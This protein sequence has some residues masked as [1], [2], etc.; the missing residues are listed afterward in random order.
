MR[1]A[2]GCSRKGGMS[3]GDQHRKLSL[4]SLCE[5]DAA[6]ERIERA[7]REGNLEATGKWTPGQILNHLAAWIEYGY[8]GYPRE[9]RPPPLALRLLL[10]M[11]RKR[12]MSRPLPVGFRIPG[13]AEGTFG[14]DVV[15]FEE[16][17]TRLRRNL[18][19]L[20]GGEA[21]KFASPAFGPLTHGEAV[22]MTLRHAELHLGFLR[23]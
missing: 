9:L 17:M 21:P 1:S 22:Q 2:V 11:G 4:S 8:E 10:R 6:L 16:G 13:A 20:V 23:Y 14:T 3:A 5:L 15:P 18:E 7:Y 12:F 19:R